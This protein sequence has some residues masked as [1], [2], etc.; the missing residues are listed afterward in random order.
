MGGVI[1]YLLPAMAQARTIV[2]VDPATGARLTRRTARTYVAVVVVGDPAQG[3]AVAATWCG[4]PD[5]AEKALRKFSREDARLAPVVEDPWAEAVPALADA[6]PSPAL[7]G[8]ARPAATPEPLAQVE[9]DPYRRGEW[10]RTGIGPDPVAVAERRA[11]RW[12]ER[13]PEHSYRVVPVPARAVLPG[14]AE[15]P[16][17]VAQDGPAPE[18]PNLAG[19]ARAL[20][21]GLTE[22]APTP[23]SLRARAAVR[24]ADEADTLISWADSL[25]PAPTGDAWAGQPWDPGTPEARARVALQGERVAT[26]WPISQA[27][28]GA[29]FELPPVWWADGPILAGERTYGDALAALPLGAIA[30]AAAALAALPPVT[31]AQARALRLCRGE[32][33]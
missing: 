12:A 33:V 26:L 30:A 23:D 2:A 18:L 13:N 4:R 14:E 17:L 31:A 15:P 6:A 21:A 7:P 27:V 5:L 9:V 3:R 25:S 28:R 24:G 29:G 11:A 8:E 19:C 32:A 22:P 1:A 16:A 10:Q 20:A